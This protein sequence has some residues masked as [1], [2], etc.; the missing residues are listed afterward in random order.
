[1]AIVADILQELTDKGA[2]GFA[3]VDQM[4]VVDDK[5]KALPDTGVEFID[6]ER[7]KLLAGDAPG[8]KIA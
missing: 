7:D 2:N 8:L 6:E 3:V 5:H 4:I 1:M